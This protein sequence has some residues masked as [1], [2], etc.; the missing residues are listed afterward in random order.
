[1]LGLCDVKQ[2]AKKYFLDTCER[3]AEREVKKD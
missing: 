3:W 2:W 1:M